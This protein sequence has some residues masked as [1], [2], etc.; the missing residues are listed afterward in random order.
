M[1][2][3]YLQLFI[4]SVSGIVLVAGTWYLL[5]R[6]ILK[7]S[8]ESK[9]PRQELEK[10]PSQSGRKFQVKRRTQAH[11][12]RNLV[13]LSGLALTL[14]GVWGYFAYHAAEG[15]Y[16]KWLRPVYYERAAETT[17]KQALAFLE[18]GKLSGAIRVFSESIRK[19]PDN[20]HLYRGFASLLRQIG[21]RAAIE[22]QQQ[23]IALNE[24]QS[25][26][27]ELNLLEYLIAFRNVEGGLAQFRSLPSDVLQSAE[28]LRL[29]SA[30]WLV[31]D[32][33]QTAR[34][35]H[36]Q[37]YEQA[38]E[39]PGIRLEHELWAL[40]DLSK[41]ERSLRLRTSGSGTGSLPMQSVSLQILI[42]HLMQTDV[43]GEEAEPFVQAI[44][45]STRPWEPG[46]F[47]YLI[48]LDRYRPE[49]VQQEMNTLI[50]DP[51]VRRRSFTRLMP[52][53]V[54]N[55]HMDAAYRLATVQDPE[56]DN[57]SQA[58][59]WEARIRVER[60]EI[61]A[62]RLC[63][64][65]PGWVTMRSLRGAYE[66]W[67]NRAEM[68]GNEPDPEEALTGESGEGWQSALYWLRRET[69]LADLLYGTVTGWG[70]E[71]E[72]EDVLFV[73]ASND[74]PRRQWATARLLALSI[75]RGDMIRY[76]EVINAALR[77]DP[78]NIQLQNDSVYLTSLINPKGEVIDR[79]SQLY[80]DHE[81]DAKVRGTFAFLLAT[82]GNQ[83]EALNVLK[84]VSE[85]SLRNSPDA[86][87]YAL[88]LELEDPERALIFA[89]SALPY[90]IFPQERALCSQ[91]IQRLEKKIE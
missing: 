22:F 81:D 87:A 28:A 30:L 78:A 55:G 62:L 44:K 17:E 24:S 1:I 33:P 43:L 34:G 54:G 31:R 85:E 3:S 86:L 14:W 70:W 32:L 64:E 66:E 48:W 38:P 80:F 20:V 41:D 18:E 45:Q 75:E 13:V 49:Q 26:E 65:K 77:F 82:I 6:V 50:D 7:W 76:L 51:V 91:L 21:D 69:H 71:S 40:A 5:F 58:L 46:Y 67:V 27:D 56:L 36:R 83:R 8:K 47:I 15:V 90:L 16:K 4:L 60:K 84:G 19:A 68:R 79:A 59:L 2:S 29:K 88:A 52:W 10:A 35:F 53:L 72:S 61:Q 25:S 12:I 37:A 73:M 89:R 11:R 23:A 9:L 39:D 42:T 63:L 57:Y 74:H